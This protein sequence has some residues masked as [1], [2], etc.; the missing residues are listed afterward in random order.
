MKNATAAQA[1]GQ[2][3]DREEEIIRKH[4][5]LIRYTAIPFVGRGVTLD[6][7]I[8]EG[9]LALIEIARDRW[10]ESRG[11]KLWT[12]ARRFVLGAMVRY[13]TQEIDEP[14]RDA[15]F[16]SGEVHEH[17]DHR[18]SID[19]VAADTLTPE[20]LVE[21]DEDLTRLEE[22]LEALSADELQI[23]W[24]RFGED[25]SLRDVERETGHGH[26]CVLRTFH[27]AMEKLRDRMEA[28]A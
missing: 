1:S 21:L 15:E 12:Y 26:G 13:L 28:R 24:K 23:L 2:D 5:H 6:D 22:D 27:G 16:V 8:Q 3:R 4:D 18:H 14:C 19:D 9:R 17:E 11:V 25:K 20:E 10:D 7:L